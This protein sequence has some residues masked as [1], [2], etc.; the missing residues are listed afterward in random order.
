MND[1]QIFNPFEGNAAVADSHKSWASESIADFCNLARIVHDAGFDWWQ[2]DVVGEIA[3]FGR[4][5]RDKDRAVF[6]VGIVGGKK[7]PTLRVHGL[8]KGISEIPRTPVTAALNERLK[9]ILFSSG[10]VLNKKYAESSNNIG[11]WP[12]HYSIEVGGG[13]QKLKDIAYDLE[14]LEMSDDE[15]EKLKPKKLMELY[16]TSKTKLGKFRVGQSIFR[17]NV[18]DRARKKC[19]VTGVL[20][21]K[22]LIASHIVS[23]KDCESGEDRL[24]GNNGLLLT[25]NL[26]KLFDRGV[27]SFSDDGNML[28]STDDNEKLL[29]QLS[30]FESWGKTCLLNKPNP[31]Q[32]KF[33]T[34][35]RAKYKI[36]NA[37]I[38]LP[39]LVMPRK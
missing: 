33:L 7:N 37:S 12:N 9:K 17:K 35:H 26:D 15:L 3:R 10:N 21:A 13:T 31:E 36:Q 32:I 27:I 23:W 5:H 6:V 19:E 39:S 25:P 4:K 22:V 11:N 8:V 1:K 30:T 18:M 16:E 24:D 29:R 34:K 38:F 20:D 28:V 2:T 14:L